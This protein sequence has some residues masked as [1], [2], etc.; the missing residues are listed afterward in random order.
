MPHEKPPLASLLAAASPALLTAAL[1]APGCFDPLAP[2][3]AAPATTWLLLFA[4]AAS[5]AASFAVART[6]A[7]LPRIAFAA[8][9]FA[10]AVSIFASLSL[11]ETLLV[12]DGRRF[13]FAVFVAMLAPAAGAYAILTARRAGLL[14]LALV[15]VAVGFAGPALAN[16][17][18]AA[19]ELLRQAMVDA[20]G[21]GASSLA[22]LERRALLRPWTLARYPRRLADLDDSLV[23][24][25]THDGFDV[26]LERWSDDL[27][28]VHGWILLKLA[29]APDLPKAQVD[30][31]LLR[32]GRERILFAKDP[33]ASPEPFTAGGIF[34]RDALRLTEGLAA[35]DALRVRIATAWSAVEL[36]STRVHAPEEQREA[37]EL[38]RDLYDANHLDRTHPLYLATLSIDAG[39]FVEAGDAP[40]YLAFFDGLATGAWP[41]P[42]KKKFAERAALVR[43]HPE[44]GYAPVMLYLRAKLASDHDQDARPFYEELQKAWPASSIARQARDEDDAAA[45]APNP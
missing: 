5:L 7:R 23:F 33:L 15:G 45:L 32:A 35:P 30:R 3:S 10:L 29:A 40:G 36:F 13:G 31:D 42:L 24:F 39:R 12:R 19:D 11:A 17:R 25:D 37:I 28:L 4:S 6:G 44:S 9:L 20:P 22:A 43:A 1:L 2:L 34:M 18:Y 27:H 38:L 21:W 26:P 8:L 14:L 16:D 41:E